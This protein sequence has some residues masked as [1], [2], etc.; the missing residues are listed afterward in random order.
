MIWIYIICKEEQILVH[1]D[2][3]LSCLVE[4]CL[5]G[6]RRVINKQFR[7]R[8]RS[9]SESATVK[10]QDPPA[11]SPSAVGG[12]DL[13]MDIQKKRNAGDPIFIAMI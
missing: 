12:V 9:L 8:F 7:F 5:P 3:G 2:N 11:F 10:T 1:Q 6:D 4:D 13:E